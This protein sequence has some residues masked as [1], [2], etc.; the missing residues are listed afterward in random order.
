MLRALSTLT[1]VALIVLAPIVRAQIVDPPATSP[2]TGFVYDVEGRVVVGA[3]IELVN[4]ANAVLAREITDARGRFAFAEVDRARLSTGDLAVMLDKRRIDIPPRAVSGES[5]V[6][7]ISTPGNPIR[8]TALAAGETVVNPNKEEDDDKAGYWW[9][10]SSKIKLALGAGG[11]I[12]LAG[13]TYLVVDNNLDDDDDPLT[14]PIF[15]RETPIT[16]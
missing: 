6:I 11:L 14:N 13:G 12:A 5:M 15:V 3:A 7:V 8:V 10:S 1:C 4:R 16:P 9:W 2:L